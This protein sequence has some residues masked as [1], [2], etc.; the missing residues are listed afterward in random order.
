MSKIDIDFNS[1]QPKSKEDKYGDDDMFESWADMNVFFPIAKPL[2][3]PLYCM[4]LTPNMVTILSTI[5]TFLSIYYLHLDN[6]YFACAAYLFGYTLDCIDGR[7]ARKYSMGSDIGMALDCTSDNISNAALF[8]YILYNRPMNLKNI[9][10]LTILAGL[11]YMLA[12]SFGLN[13]AIATYETTGSDNFYEKRVK[14][15]EGKGYG[16]EKELFN[17][18]LL[19]NKTSYS[20]YKKFFPTYD[21]EKITKWLK[22]LKHFGP[23]NYCLF[24]GFL[25]LII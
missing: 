8:M 7:M 12:I 2:I 24:V 19:I 6:R 23:G 1:K 9:G 22:V 3:D 21:K 18:F 17:L 13:E 4:G 14:Q 16:Y 25:L 5:F 11:S 10:L 15:L 20:T